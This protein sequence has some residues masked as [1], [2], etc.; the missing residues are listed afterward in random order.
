LG[1]RRVFDTFSVAVNHREVGS[2][3]GEAISKTLLLG[4]PSFMGIRAGT[5]TPG[6]VSGGHGLLLRFHLPLPTAAAAV[7]VGMMFHA[8]MM[9]TVR[10]IV[11][12]SAASLLLVLLLHLLKL[13][14]D[15]LGHGRNA[16]VPAA[17]SNPVG[18]TLKVRRLQR[19]CEKKEMLRL[20]CVLP[21][22]KGG[23]SLVIF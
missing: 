20:V 2:P 5:S 7:T 23:I 13:Q 4:S 14:L 21:F 19:H 11:R 22:F 6:V 1:H 3:D 16:V 10:V 17:S 8:V 12:V 18:W 9:M 15:V